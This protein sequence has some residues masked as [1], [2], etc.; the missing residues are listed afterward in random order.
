MP[1]HDLRFELLGSLDELNS[2]LGLV[3]TKITEMQQAA[4]I[5]SLQNRIMT[6]S[7]YIADDYNDE[8]LISESDV[9]E[10]ENKTREMRTL[11]PKQ[12]LLTIPGHNEVSAHID[13]SRTIARRVERNLSRAHETKPMPESVL[14]FMNSLSGF[15]FAFARYVE[16]KMKSETIEKKDVWS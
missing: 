6:L 12:T 13:V 14:E 7:A 3:K 5:E 15:L 11:Y 8:Y 9:A 1:K 4:F 10:L 16:H 2:V